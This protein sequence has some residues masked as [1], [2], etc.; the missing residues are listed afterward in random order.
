MNDESQNIKLHRV[1]DTVKSSFLSSIHVQ[2]GSEA[3]NAPPVRFVCS[4]IPIP[5]LYEIWSNVSYFRCGA[6]C[7]IGIEVSQAR[8]AMTKFML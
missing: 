4:S 2:D 3:E 6:Y 8:N 5:C 7:E 1:I